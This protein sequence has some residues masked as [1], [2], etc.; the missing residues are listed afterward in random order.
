VRA[1]SSP[2][3]FWFDVSRVSGRVVVT[4]HGTLDTSVSPVLARVLRD[5]IDDQG[6]MAVVVD[7]GDVTV[8]DLACT[9][10][11]LAAAC[12]AAS[13]GGELIVAAPPAAVAWALEAADAKGGIAVTGPTARTP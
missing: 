10:V 11:L 6:N 3:G 7:L 2:R 4:A 12:S 8:A 1:P 5:L 13:R 9:G